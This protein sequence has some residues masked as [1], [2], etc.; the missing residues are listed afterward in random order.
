RLPVAL[1]PADGGHLQGHLLQ[2]NPCREERLTLHAN[3]PESRAREA[4]EGSP[5]SPRCILIADP[6]PH[7]LRCSAVGGSGL[8]IG[9]SALMNASTRFR[10]AV[11]LSLGLGLLAVAPGRGSED[12]PKAAKATLTVLLP[13][14][15][16]YEPTELKVNGKLLMG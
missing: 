4:P 11:A 16:E 6:V 9:E 8:P 5:G 15:H 13:K 14:M 3:Q 10:I 1:R 12:K 7:L 2:G